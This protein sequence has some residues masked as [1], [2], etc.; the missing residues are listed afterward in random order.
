MEAMLSGRFREAPADV[1]VA[2]AWPENDPVTGT[3]IVARVHGAC[4]EL[5]LRRAGGHCEVIANGT[6]LMDTRC[7][8][9]E[10]LLVGAALDRHSAG[11]ILLGGL[12]VGFSL[13]AALDRAEVSSVVVVER[14][15]A[16]IDWNRAGGPLAGWHGA[17]LEDARVEV[18][19]ADLL[20]YVPAYAGF[21]AICLDIDNGPGWTVD[22]GNAALYRACGIDKLCASLRPCGVLS[23]WSAEAA[24]AFE[25]ALALRFGE[26]EVRTVPVPRGEP[27]VIYVAAGPRAPARSS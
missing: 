26:V 11:R 13:R 8:E 20:G 9:S 12:G 10:R 15:Q 18:V 1:A 4:G 17:A 7:G 6:F 25:R 27:D 23:V 21:D 16:V 5:V 22:A 14:E 24:P 2:A 19:H 3:E